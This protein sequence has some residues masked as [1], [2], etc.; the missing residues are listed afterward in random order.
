MARVMALDYGV[1]R[2][3]IAVTDELQMIASGLTTVDTS[4]LL[5]FLEDYFKKE[6][7][8][9]VVV[10]EPKQKDNS[11]SQSEVF[12]AEFLKKFTE[13]F[14]EMKLVR[15]DER[16]TSKMAFQTMIDSGL[17]KKKRQNKALVDEVSATIILQS[18]L[19]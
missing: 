10:G 7:V 5:N 14:P 19:Y 16:F 15:V 18:Y 4:S 11:A 3:G 17:K 2:T 6:K 8:E 1:K 9:T 13:K 12:I